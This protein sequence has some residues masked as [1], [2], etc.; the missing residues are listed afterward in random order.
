MMGN[1]V[2]RFQKPGIQIP[3]RSFYN[4]IRRSALEILLTL[5]SSN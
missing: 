3:D 5:K 2:S 4:G 1:S